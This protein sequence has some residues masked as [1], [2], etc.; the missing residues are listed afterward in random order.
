MTAKPNPH[1]DKTRPRLRAAGWGLLALSLLLGIVG[2]HLTAGN[3][4]ADIGN[5]M[6]DINLANLGW[7]IVAMIMAALALM[8]FIAQ[9]VLRPR[10][11]NSHP[12][13]NSQS[14]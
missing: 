13:E 2:P 4:P 7:I 8:C 12:S 9:W 6:G 11:D 14:K 3:L 10:E 5:R 1:P